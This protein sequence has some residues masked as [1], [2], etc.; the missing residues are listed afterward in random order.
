MNF[1]GFS[2]ETFRFLEGLAENN[3][4][5]WFEENRKTYE[6][7]LKNPL[8]DLALDVGTYMATLDPEF[9]VSPQRAVARI[10]RD[11]RFSNDKSP[12]KT[13][14]WASWTN[15]TWE[16]APGFYFEVG[17]S[18]Y[19]YGMGFYQNKKETIKRFQERI[20]DNP[21]HFKEITSFL[22]EGNFKVLGEKYKRVPDEAPK[23]LEQ[24]W[25]FKSVYVGYSSADTDQVKYP[26]FVNKLIDEYKKITSLYNFFMDLRG[27]A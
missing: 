23:G 12:Y 10:N 26:N 2:D 22:S 27:E 9:D 14:L 8:Y 6:K 4:K 17:I 21:K 24:W 7:H 18:G 3:N 25:G 15:K 16:E 11:I 5:A 19:G 1:K 13:N 20:S